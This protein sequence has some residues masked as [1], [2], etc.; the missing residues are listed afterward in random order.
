MAFFAYKCTSR[1]GL[2][3]QSGSYGKKGLVS[4]MTLVYHTHPASLCTVEDI[5]A[6]M[7][8]R[9]RRHVHR[10]YHDLSDLLQ[11]EL[12][13]V[14][15]VT[16]WDEYRLGKLKLTHEPR[17][18]MQAGKTGILR[19]LED[20]ARETGVYIQVGNKRVLQ[21]RE[22]NE[23]ALASDDPDAPDTNETIDF[24]AI[25]AKKSG[26][27]GSDPE[28]GAADARID[29]EWLYTKATALIPDNERPDCL[30]LIRSLAFDDRHVG[31]DFRTLRGWSTERYYKTL[32]RLKDVFHEAAGKQRPP[33]AQNHR[34]F[35]PEQVIQFW[36]RGYGPARIA[37][38]VGCSSS[39]ADQIIQ[40]ARQQGRLPMRSA[41]RAYTH[42]KIVRENERH[43][44]IE[45]F[46]RSAVYA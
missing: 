29:F 19:H 27:G 10:R 45:H 22:Y 35:D 42:H 33:K 16:M 3:H 21:Q 23:S 24:H 41:E 2:A 40:A 26:S 31:V 34:S 8:P 37:R 28:G 43:L 17:F 1:P 13:Q 39:R 11:D 12:A 9:V 32:D 25:R 7:E 14:A 15:L 36:S 38:L 20:L 44:Y 6:D 30:E 46:D 4:A 5:L 18:W